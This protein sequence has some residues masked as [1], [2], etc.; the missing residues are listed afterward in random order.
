MQD[1]LLAASV[2]LLGA[3]AYFWFADP[4]VSKVVEPVDLRE[5]AEV[6]VVLGEDGYVPAKLRISQGATVVFTST[7]SWNFWPASNSHPA[8]DVYPEF[9]PERPLTPDEKWEFT[10]ERE[11][12]WGFHDHLRSYYNGIIYVEAQ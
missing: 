2:L 4:S 3:S 6:E 11:G 5:R 9:D 8:H 1:V 10:F 7:Q 12:T